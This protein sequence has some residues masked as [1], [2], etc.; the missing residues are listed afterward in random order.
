MLD[1]ETR[2]AA[3]H[4]AAELLRDTI[5]TDYS[6]TTLRVTADHLLSFH[7][8]QSRITDAKAE[9]AID[10]LFEIASSDTGQSARVARFLMAWWNGTDLGD[11][12]IADL[13]G[14][15]TAIADDISTV[16]T[17]LGRHPGAVYVNAF[18]RRS[19]MVA[20]IERNGTL[21]EVRA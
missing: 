11:F 5:G 18:N 19:D 12:P 2:R 13:F 20:L 8:A 3:E 21:Q 1:A 4:A 10:R 16:V 9:S 6:D 15:D 14:L 17:W 7:R